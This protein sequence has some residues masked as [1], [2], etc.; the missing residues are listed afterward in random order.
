MQKFASSILDWLAADN[1]WFG[2][3]AQNWMLVIGAGLVLYIVGL[4]IASR[5]EPRA[6]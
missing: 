5:R 2:V 1:A 6:R 4:A 3:P